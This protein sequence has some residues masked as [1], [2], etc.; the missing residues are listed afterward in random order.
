MSMPYAIQFRRILDR[1][2]TLISVSATVN[3]H[4][5]KLVALGLTFCRSLPTKEGVVEN[6]KIRVYLR[7]CSDSE[8]G[9]IT[10]LKHLGYYIGYKVT[11][12][13]YFVSKN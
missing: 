11:C 1:V 7:V 10:Y 5:S 4:Q 9:N 2:T 6:T 12:K 8:N 3:P 13:L